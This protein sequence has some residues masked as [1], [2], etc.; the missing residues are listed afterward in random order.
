MTARWSFPKLGTGFALAVWAI[1]FWYLIATD[2]V[3]LY[4][5]S[6]TTWLAPMGAIALTVAMAG[7]LLSARVSRHEPLTRRHL[8]TLLVLIVPALIITTSPPVALGSFA[9]SRRPVATNGDY[10]SK[11][12]RSIG[13]GDLSLLDILQLNRTGE[14]DKL[15]ARAGSTSSFTGFVTKDPNDRADE[16]R[17]NRFVISC[18]PGDAVPIQLRVVG[19]P[20]GEVEADDWVRITGSIYPVGPEVIVDASEVDRVPRPEHP[21]LNSN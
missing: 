16:F 6:R 7:Q 11:E 5:S 12:G 8:G 4:F 19:A 9:V 1:A 18:C 13:E 17:L 3:A 21:Y 14:L 20:P 2:R 10:V 15:A